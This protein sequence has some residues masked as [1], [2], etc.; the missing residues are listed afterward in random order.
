VRR[1]LIAGL[2]AVPA[3]ACGQPAPISPAAGGD[4][5]RAVAQASVEVE[6]VDVTQNI[7][8]QMD[9]YLLKSG[10]RARQL[11]H[12]LTILQGTSNVLVLSTNLDWVMHRSLAYDDALLQ[13]EGNYIKQ[14]GLTITDETIGKLYNAAG[15]EPP[16]YDTGRTPGQQGE[17]IRK[18]LAVGNGKLDEELRNLGI[19]PKDYNEAPPPQ[20]YIQMQKSLGRKTVRTAS[21]ELVGLLPVQTFEG[22]DGQGNYAIGVVAVVSPAMKELALQVL[23]AHGEIAPVAPDPARAMDVTQLFSDKTQLIR[24]FGVRRLFDSKGLPMIVSFGQWASSYS[25]TDKAVAEV[26]RR[27]AR[28]Q[29]ESRADGQ[30][31][32]FLGG[33]MKVDVASDTGAKLD[34]TADRLSDGYKQD[35]IATTSVA[36]EINEILHNRA[37]EKVTGVETLSS[38]SQKHPETGQQIIGVIRIWSAAGEKATRATRDK[39]GPVATAVAV[40]DHPNG[41]PAVAKGRDL[42][43]ASDF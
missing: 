21:G 10:L 2:V 13:A 7:N 12:E 23:T 29:A 27:V 18:I 25:G 41:A 32:Q 9:A 38:W 42:M 37:H 40:P 36:N 1:L 33:S 28:E 14:Q 4:V 22:H 11:K 20:R 26:A 39:R 19:D 15:Q 35:N 31:A 34:K 17:L 5:V 8:D 3:L 6:P 30:I 16:P 43:Q 24:D